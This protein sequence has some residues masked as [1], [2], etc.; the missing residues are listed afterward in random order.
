MQ[1]DEVVEK[2]QSDLRA[3]VLGP[4]WRAD[5]KRAGVRR[6][7]GDFFRQDVEEEE[8]SSESSETSDDSDDIEDG[9]EMEDIGNEA[10]DP[11]SKVKKK[12][13]GRVTIVV[14]ED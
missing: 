8:E 11:E 4:E 7:R 14:H 10:E 3:G 12:I 9:F 13:P 1:L 5:A 6:A 2:F